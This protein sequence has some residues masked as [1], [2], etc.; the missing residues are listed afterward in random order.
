MENNSN[1]DSQNKGVC[2]KPLDDLSNH[3]PN[4]S[5]HKLSVSDSETLDD[6][7]NR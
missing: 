1:P 3:A 7:Q 5:H 4:P 6:G 2:D